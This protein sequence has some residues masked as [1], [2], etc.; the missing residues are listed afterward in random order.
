MLEVVRRE[1]VKIEK[2]KKAD[3]VFVDTAVD[4]IRI[5]ADRTHQGKEDDDFFPASREYFT[6]EEDQAM[7]EEFWRF[8]RRM[9]HEKYTSLVDALEKRG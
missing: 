4:F 6:D 8:D 5:Y 2:E 1:I 9:I 3:P 7:L